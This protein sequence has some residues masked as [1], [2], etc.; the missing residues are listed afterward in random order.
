M[1]TQT[2]YTLYVVLPHGPANI[3]SV[4]QSRSE[5]VTAF[6]DRLPAYRDNSRELCL[7]RDVDEF[8][9]ASSHA[10]DPHNPYA[11]DKSDTCARCKATNAYVREVHFPLSDEYITLCTDC[12][13]DDVA[14]S[15][16]E[17]WH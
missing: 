11:Y 3:A 5:A 8:M 7:Y 1:E 16:F 2:T 15:S 9:I 4:Y 17:L 6:N 14:V 13:P 10:K 12:E